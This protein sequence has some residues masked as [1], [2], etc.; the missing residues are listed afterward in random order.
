MAESRDVDA[1]PRFR[2]DSERWTDWGWE[3]QGTDWSSRP[4]PLPEPT[5]EEAPDGR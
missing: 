4:R 5:P 1:E 3:Q 2:N